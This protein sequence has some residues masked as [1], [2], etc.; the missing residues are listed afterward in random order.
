MAN[1]VRKNSKRN[2]RRNKRNIRRTTRKNVRIRTK[3]IETRNQ[4]INRLNRSRKKRKG[5]NTL[6]NKKSITNYFSKNELNKLN[7]MLKKNATLFKFKPFNNIF[8]FIFSL[9][10]NIFN[11]IYNNFSYG[12]STLGTRKFLKYFF[13]Q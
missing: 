8:F 6:L 1:S 13:K 7:K 10:S 3:R 5:R 12:N 4:R 11:P 2:S 9:I